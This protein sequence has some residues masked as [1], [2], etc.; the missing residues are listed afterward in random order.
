M[1]DTQDRFLKKDC[2]LGYFMMW[3]FQEGDRI[4]PQHLIAI[5]LDELQN[6]GVRWHRVGNIANIQKR[7]TTPCHLRLV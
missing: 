7:L 4:Y 5:A 1:V 2:F 6:A 3:I